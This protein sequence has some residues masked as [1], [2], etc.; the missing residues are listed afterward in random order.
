MISWLA[1]CRGA[2]SSAL[3]CLPVAGYFELFRAA[4]GSRMRDICTLVSCGIVSRGQLDTISWSDNDKELILINDCFLNVLHIHD[5]VSSSSCLAC[6]SQGRGVQR[7]LPLSHCE[8][9]AN[10]CRE[11]C[12]VHVGPCRELEH[13]L[14][15]RNAQAG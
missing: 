13:W 6:A 11:R 5:E 2:P 4:R 12:F 3:A 8:T 15:A 7:R 14:V 9:S 1:L 10:D